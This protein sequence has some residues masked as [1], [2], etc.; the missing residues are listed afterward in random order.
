MACI[1]KITNLVNGKMYVGQTKYSVRHRWQEHRYAAITPSYLPKQYIHK[2]MA[3]YGIENF[4]IEC[5][6]ECA[7]ELLTE[8]ETYWI[9]KLDTFRNGYNLNEG[10]NQKPLTQRRRLRKWN[11]EH[12]QSTAKP[13]S[14]FTLD[15]R[16]IK[17]YSSTNSAALEAGTDC[18][19]V[20]RCCKGKRRTAGG[21][22]WC[23]KGEEHKIV[24]LQFGKRAPNKSKIV[25]AMS[26][27]G[28]TLTF[29]NSAEAA[30]FVG[31]TYETAI[32]H[33]CNGTIRNNFYK[34][35]YWKYLN[36]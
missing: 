23:Y 30:K 15:G 1:Y 7:I 35:Y 2:A 20:E 6:E 33:R 5:L 8:R 25:V 18:K 29:M 3:K 24:P 36:N 14:Q 16:F 17:A 22:L 4:K 27:S 26:E 28:E 32:R 10:G 19:S 34:G 13:V 9:A 12:P 11:D 31:A 21:Y